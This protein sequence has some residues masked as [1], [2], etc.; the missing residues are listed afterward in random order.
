MQMPQGFCHWAWCDIQ[1]HVL[2]LARGGDL[3][4][5]R[6]GRSVTCCTDGSRPVIFGLE[7]LQPAGR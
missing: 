2:T 1:K 6:A 5:P 7:R 4:G 3:L